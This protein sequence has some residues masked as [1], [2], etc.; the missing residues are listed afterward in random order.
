MS[1]GI[2]KTNEQHGEGTNQRREMS[3][4]QFLT[5]T[6]GATGGFLAAGITIPMIR[7]AVDPLLSKK[8]ASEFVKVAELDKI[9][10]EPVEVRFEVQQV[11]GWV[12]SNPELIAWILKNDTGEVIALSPVC[13][14]LGC[15][16]NWEKAKNEFFCPCHAAEYTK[17]GKNLKVAPLPLDEYAVKVENGSIY[18]GQIQPNRL[19]GQKA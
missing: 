6:L 17:E 4:R 15:T 5:Y 13:K 16:V 14:H 7:F 3:R 2:A 18:L 1:D 8:E 11:D 9:G 12:E 19:T 10:N